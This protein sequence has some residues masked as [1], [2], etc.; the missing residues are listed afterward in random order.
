LGSDLCKVFPDAVKLAHRELDI[1]NREQVLKSIQGIKPDVVINA[2]A[3]TDVDGCEDNRELALQVNGYGPGHIAEACNKTGATLV[4]FS[5]DYVFD[6]SRNEYIESDTPNPINVYGQSKLLGEQK[7][8]ESASDYR[9][10]RIS[11]LFGTH[12]RNFVETMLKLSPQ[13][14][15]VK[16]VND[17][18]GKP[19]YTVDLANKI[20]EI[21]E[22]EPGIYHLT[23]D[24]V[25][26][27]YE[28]ASA[29]IDNVVPC[30]SE[31]FPR[32]AKRPKYSVLINTKTESLRHWKE[33]LKAYM[34]E[35]NE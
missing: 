21:L 31:E 35:R 10:I 22:L 33:A 13:V 25:C 34:K 20:T 28:F 32:K 15:R 7:I 6:G 11:W 23:N 24:G 1:T 27:W 29:I 5:T 18:F 4:H 16:L 8:A 3:Y 30:T 17:Q 9:I 26:S 12:G 19:T 14:Y 2:A